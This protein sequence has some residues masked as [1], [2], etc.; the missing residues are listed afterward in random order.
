[1]YYTI[2]TAMQDDAPDIGGIISSA[3][4]SAYVG[5]VP[6]KTLD[7]LTAEN[8]T[9]KMAASIESGAMLARLLWQ[10]G[11]AIGVAVICPARHEEHRGMGEIVALYVRPEYWRQGFGAALLTDALMMLNRRG[12]ANNYLWVLEENA[13]ARA[14]YE[15]FGFVRQEGEQLQVTLGGKELTEL[16]YVFSGPPGCRCERPAEG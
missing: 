16:C 15:A 10:G 7:E 2:K 1:M 13:R 9:E 8:W 4:K 11:E 14:F 5:I 12:F 6:Q 3:W